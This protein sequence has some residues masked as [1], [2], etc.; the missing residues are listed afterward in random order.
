MKRKPLTT[1][2]IND[3]IRM[4]QSGEISSTHR[5][6]EKFKTSHKKISMILKDNNIS[7]NNRGGQLKFDI[8]QQYSKLKE[9]KAKDGQIIIA[10]CKKTQKEFYDYQN[11]SGTLTDHVKNTYPNAYIPNSYYERKKIYKITGKNWFDDYFNFAEKEIE[12]TRKCKYCEWETTDIDNKTGCYET[13]LKDKH[14]ISINELISQHPNE[15]KYHTNYQRDKE[16]NEIL[17]NKENFVICQL[18]NQKMKVISNTHLNNKHNI[19]Q[20]EYKKLFPNNNLVSNVK[21]VE[22]RN[23]LHNLNV[24]MVYKFSSKGETDVNT[25]IES[26]GFVTFKSGNKKLLDGI[27]VDIIIEDKKIGIEYNGNF[28]HT[29]KFGG[30]NSTYH[31]NKTIRMAEKGYKLIHI[32]EDEW[33]LNEDVVKSK[34]SHILGVSTGQ[35]IGARKCQINE[36]N[37]KEKNIFLNKY[38]IQGSDRSNINIG[39]FYNGE[40]VGVM[41]FDNQR[42]MVSQGNDKDTYDLR[43]YATNHNFIISGLGDKIFK[44]FIKNYNPSKVLSF[45][46][47][48]WTLDAHN[49]FYTKIGFKFT[50]IIDPRYFYYNSKEDRYKRYHKFQFGKKT[51]I[52]KYDADPSKSEWQIMQSLGWDRIWDCGL[53]KYEWTKT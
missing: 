51:L 9:K 2:D 1:D 38:H 14:N 29:E 50:N 11:K 36:I 26:L 13:H 15:L 24:N 45:A 41:T 33:K 25:Y 17:S 52:K 10:I 37:P 48:R 4:Y 6:A 27:E 18:C 43:R 20:N 49:N 22:F 44:Y 16:R 31:L 53:F 7:I 28:W 42:N 46:D 34:L 47:R 5:L 21:T 8:P 40:L 19:T 23:H 3:I 32:F 39:A 30:K 35:K 12:Q